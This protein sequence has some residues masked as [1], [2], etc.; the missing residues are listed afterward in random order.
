LPKSPP[1]P[2]LYC[3]PGGVLS[4][5]GSGLQEFLAAV[6]AKGACFRFRARGFSMYP[7][8]QD[9]DVIT[10]SPRDSPFRPGEV[11]AFCHPE[12]QKL[13]VHRL[14]SRIPGGYLMGGDSSPEGDGF[15]PL[16]N[17]FGT[18]SRV[19]RQGQPVRLGL[20]PEGR[21]IAWLSRHNLLQPL[22]HRTAQILHPALHRLPK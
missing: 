10:I 3:K 13:V 15:I 11:V 1:K 2:L 5:S 6:L 16:D 7:F 18:V 9:G 20:G 12:T 17:V 19:E 8:I 4:L 14:L 22:V 21:L